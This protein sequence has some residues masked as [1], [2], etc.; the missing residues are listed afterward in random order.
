MEKVKNI[1]KAVNAKIEDYQKKQEAL[2]TKIN[3]IAEDL[4][5]TDF[6]FIGKNE[7]NGVVF[8]A[9]G[10]VLINLGLVETAKKLMMDRGSIE[11]KA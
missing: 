5:L 11:K 4:K 2:D 3:A 9:S 1:D 6:T 10:G 8:R 7:T